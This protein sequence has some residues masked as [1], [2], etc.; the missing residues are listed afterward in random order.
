M[1]H[2]LIQRIVEELRT[3]LTG[4]FLGKIFQL[5]PLSF[6]LDFGLRGEYLFIS[7]DPASPRL[8][9]IRRRLKELEK[10][11]VA[12]NAFGQQMRTTLGGAYLS[13]ISKDPYDRIVRLTFRI[14]DELHGIF[15]AGL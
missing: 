4:R 12:L 9:L 5:S 13:N 6:A 14:D 11:S 3:T 15:F 2:A 8:Y 1:D 7:T 10:Q